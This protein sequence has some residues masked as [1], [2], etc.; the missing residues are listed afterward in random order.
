MILTST[1]A[2]DKGLRSVVNK[3]VVQVA[4]K[5]GFVPWA[6]DN[7]PLND[8]PTMLVGIDV[9]GNQAGSNGSTTYGMTATIDPYFC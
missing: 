5:L 8:Q 6:I 4:A 9:S 1:L 2:K 3:M 7:L